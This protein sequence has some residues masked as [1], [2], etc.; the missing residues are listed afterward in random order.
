MFMSKTEVVLFTTVYPVTEILHNMVRLV[1]YNPVLV[2]F[3]FLR[4]F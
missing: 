4:I 2:E 3:T 1:I